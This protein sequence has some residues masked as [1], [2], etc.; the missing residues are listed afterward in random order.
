MGFGEIDQGCPFHLGWCRHLGWEGACCPFYL[1]SSQPV[2]QMEVSEGVAPVA[3]V[4]LFTS[5]PLRGCT[6]LVVPADLGVSNVD[7]S[8][9]GLV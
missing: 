6:W 2:A 9:L 1:L 4:L 5:F 8:L 3:K 7:M